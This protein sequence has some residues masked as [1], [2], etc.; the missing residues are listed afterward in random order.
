MN[1]RLKDDYIKDFYCATKIWVDYSV[2]VIV[3]EDLFIYFICYRAKY[4]IEHNNTLY[5]LQDYE[6]F[7][8]YLFDS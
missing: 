7:L 3:D 5:L 4:F 2:A 1:Q 6:R 8:T